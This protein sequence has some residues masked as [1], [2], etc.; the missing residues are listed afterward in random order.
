M[1]YHPTDGAEFGLQ[2]GQSVFTFHTGAVYLLSGRIRYHLDLEADPFNFTLGPGA[3]IGLEQSQLPE[4]FLR[5]TALEPVTARAWT[6]K[7]IETALGKH[8]DFALASLQSLS[9][10]QRRLTAELSRRLLEHARPDAGANQAFY[11]RLIGQYPQQ[12]LGQAIREALNTYAPARAGT[13]PLQLLTGPPELSQETQ[14]SLYQLAFGGFD[15]INQ[16]L[17]DRFGRCFAA[18]DVLCREG[19]TGEEVF[20]L[21]TGRVD[22]RRQQQP[23]GTLYPGDLV[24]EMAL[25]DGEARTATV[26]AAEPTEALALNRTHFQM[27]FQLHPSWTWRLMQGF[28]QRLAKAYRLLAKPEAVVAG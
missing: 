24:G 7:G 20:L 17:R 10:Q 12:D 6:Y 27:I 14:V 15:G 21:L 18:G 11:Q 1:V 2:A 19:E 4:G 3:L 25:L 22:V 28:G 26:T 5:A 8:P 16:D 23:I 9:Q 13:G